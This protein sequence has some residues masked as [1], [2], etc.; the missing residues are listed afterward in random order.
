MDI[1][2]KKKTAIILGA[3]VAIFAASATATGIIYSRKKCD[4]KSNTS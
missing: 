2:K 4:S 3:G 1:S